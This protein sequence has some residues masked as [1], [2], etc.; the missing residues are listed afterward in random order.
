MNQGVARASR[1]IYAGHVHP[2]FSISGFLCPGL[3]VRLERQHSQ[4]H[5]GYETSQVLAQAALIDVLASRTS[6]VV[7]EE[8]PYHT[9]YYRKRER[10]LMKEK[11]QGQQYLTPPAE[12][13][14]I[15]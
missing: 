10:P 13:A 14:L 15:D 6:L 12:K 9:R 11:A 1:S 7:D 4:H 3:V 2:I 5:D 8:T